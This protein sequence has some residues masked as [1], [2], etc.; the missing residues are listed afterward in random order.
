[1]GLSMAA[2]AQ[3][4]ETIEV[5]GKVVDKNNEPLVGVNIYVADNPGM[6]TVSNVDG[7]YTIEV[8]NYETLIF[9]FVGFDTQEVLI[10]DQNK[11]NVSL[12]ETEGSVLDDVVVTG[13]GAQS[14]VSITGAV[15]T[16]DVET[17][18][19]SPSSNITNALAGN[20]PGI[21]AMATSGQPG[22]SMSEF[23]IRGISTFG[24]NSSAL[25]LVDGFER[26]INELNIEDIESFTV[27]KD[28]STTA[29]YGS[30]G[31]N[32]VV[33]ITTKR[34]KAGK[35]NIDAKVQTTY[36]TRTITPEFVDGITY[37]NLINEARVTRNQAPIYQPEELEIIRL[38]LD[39][40]LYP[41]VDWQD[42][43]LRDGAM[44]YRANINVNGGG[45]IARYYVS[46]SYSEDQ[47]MYNTD[48]AIKDDYN[49]NANY[50][51]YTYRL[52]TDLDVTKS[53]LVQVGV[54]G[55]LSKR[56]S[57][58]L[59]DNDLW[60]QLFGYSPIR[61]PITY[62]NGYVPAVGTGNQTNPWVAATQTGFNEDWVSKIQT[63]I[64]VKQNFDFL[65]KGLSFTGRFGY[66]TD[67]YNTIFRRKWPE[68]WRAERA[69]DADGKLVFSKI[70]DPSEM[71]QTSSS[72]GNRKEFLD[73]MVNWGRNFNKHYFSATAKYT[74]DAFIETQ[75]LGEDLK[76][77]VARRN[78]AVAGRI[79]YDYN[80]KYFLDFNFGYTGSEN[81]A[82]GQQYGF[83][84][85]YSVAWNVAEENFIKNNLPW[86]NMLKFRF[87]H[88]KVG[89]DK[90]G[91]PNNPDR[92]PYLY[93]IESVQTPEQL[94]DGAYSYEW[95]DY[96]FDNNFS[97]LRYTQ[98]ASPYVTWEVA[99]KS[100]LGLDLSLFDDRISANVD[101]FKEKRE[102]IYMVRAFL[103]AM[104]G[105]ESQP[106]ANVGA[107]ESE[108]FDGRMAYN[109]KIGKVDVTVRGNITYSRNE[110][111]ERD[112]E[113]NAYAY[114]MQ[115]GYRVD[116]AKG[117]IS[118]GLFKDYDD[119]RNS[120][121]QTFG[122]YQPGDIKYKD[123]NGDG[124]VNNGDVVA[125]GSTQRPNLIYGVGA[126]ARWKGLDVNVHFQGAGKSSFFIY[127]KTVYAFS[128]GEWG[129]ILKGMVTEDRW[130]SSEGSGD[131]ATENTNASY[132]R[133]SF[134]GNANNYRNSTYWL[135]NGAYLRLK[136]LDIGYTLPK[137]LVNRFRI[138]DLRIFVT[139]TN[140]VTWSKFKLWDPE[141]VNP[142]GEEYPLPKSIT[143]GLTLNL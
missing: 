82:R 3:E 64:T 88:G 29:I 100:D 120:P 44:S 121:L 63:N 50:R 2:N 126:S 85:A 48:D 87:S 55:S 25:V 72:R 58:G 122:A 79:A 75:G 101:Y 56:N 140:L 19:F 96:S 113:N 51:L 115:E 12:E 33:L 10:K 89:N 70:S 59:G 65:T 62:S 76:N 43:L 42:K 9:S 84:P 133:L 132:P 81:F 98:V 112:E 71:F 23:W 95:A 15:T 108:G 137:S 36:N 105:L 54:S 7:E 104:V 66:D 18:K 117:L 16:V 106:R 92:F 26:D 93:T 127:G 61:T 45:S 103:P 57:P 135:R 107:V 139:G 116:Q 77:G 31:A 111:L 73:L 119:I 35:V 141:M 102:G 27:L 49:T 94:E 21:M 80:V 128:E 14:V 114:Q 37:A 30:R 46:G 6:G 11:L 8:P 13:T 40:D 78:Q 138:N 60:G 28:A 5:K 39:Q 47:G 86:M 32:G 90:L 118:L 130:R 129:T 123:V 136:T 38:G 41:N 74:Q 53:T 24:A 131:V 22:K 20:V 134:G 97:G 142:R 4:K 69:R 125:I 124:V 109:Q 1:M 83:F 67:N 99:T 68:Q 17:L 110:I 34:G 91:D 52:N 143:V